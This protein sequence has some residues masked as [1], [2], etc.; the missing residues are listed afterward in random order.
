MAPTTVYYTDNGGRGWATVELQA[1]LMARLFEADLVRLDASRGYSK[2]E[3]LPGLLPR[4][5]RSGFALV[6]A[7]APAHLNAVLSRHAL[8]TAHDYV[9]GWV[10]DSFW[11]D[12]IP[13]IARHRGAFDHL[14]VTDGELVDHWATSTGSPTTWLPF[15]S[16]V[17]DHGSADPDRPVDVQRFG[18]MPPTWEDEATVALRAAA[19]GIR[20]AGRTP[21]SADPVANQRSLLRAA[22]RAAFTVAFSNAAAPADYTHPTHEYLTG[23]WTDSLAAGAVVAGIPPTCQA[24]RELLWDGALLELEG[25]DLESGLAAIKAARDSW[26]P[27][28]ARHNHALALQRLDWR[29]RAQVISQVSG[30]TTPTLVAELSRLEAAIA[31]SSVP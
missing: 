16:D 8:L 12:R 27:V 6:I 7:P 30:V 26:T 14:F 18:R 29:R 28:R 5:R 10:V 2:V 3:L 22:G 20:Y 15:G 25:I 9:A 1:V 31:T 19:H 21:F 13:R 23:R 17:L 24:T 4:R 11:T